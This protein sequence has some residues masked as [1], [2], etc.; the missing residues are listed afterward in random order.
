MMINL[1]IYQNWK[2]HITWQFDHANEHI[3]NV[4]VTVKRDTEQT[5]TVEDKGVTCPGNKNSFAVKKMKIS[6]HHK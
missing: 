6:S 2:Q 4:H 3:I 1:L 5:Q